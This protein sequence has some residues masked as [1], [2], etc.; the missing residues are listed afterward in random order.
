[1]TPATAPDLAELL[2]AVYD[3]EFGFRLTNFSIKPVHVANGLGR[4]LTART[5]E[6]TAMTRMVRR[7]VR[8]QKL[9]VDEER[10]PNVEILEEFGQAFEG[11]HGHEPDAL[12]LTRLRSLAFDVLAADGRQR[13]AQVLAALQV[14]AQQ[15]GGGQ[16]DRQQHR[17]DQ[18]EDHDAP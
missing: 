13:F 12:R 16:R 7:Y 17:E 6:T 14:S 10:F 18:H 5:Y 4:A 1:M 15:E 11:R 3:E 9:G 8:N 2:Q